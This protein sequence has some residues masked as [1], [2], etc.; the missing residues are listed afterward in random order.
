MK[1]RYFLNMKDHKIHIQKVKP[2]LHT[3]FTHCQH[4]FEIISSYI[5]RPERKKNAYL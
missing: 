4:L 1:F 2:V 3:L 5:F